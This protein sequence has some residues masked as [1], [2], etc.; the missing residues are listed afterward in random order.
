MYD[1]IYQAQYLKMVSGMWQ[2]GKIYFAWL[3][4]YAVV[5]R[6][7]KKNM[8][9]KKGLTTVNPLGIGHLDLSV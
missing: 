6:T 3:N 2:V 7:N 1:N 5:Y 8:V 4:E 9:G